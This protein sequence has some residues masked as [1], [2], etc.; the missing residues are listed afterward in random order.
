MKLYLAHLRN[1]KFF[2]NHMSN[3]F[4]NNKKQFYLIRGPLGC[5][6]SLF[7]RKA[8]NNFIG[9]SD[10]LG[11]NYFKQNYQFLFCNLLNPLNEI[12]PFN[13]ISC[14]FRKIYLLIKLE[15]RINEVI[16]VI[17]KL[18]LDE[19]TI[20]DISFI[21]SMGRDDIKLLE[22]YNKDNKQ[23]NKKRKTKNKL[24]ND[25]NNTPNSEI[26]KFEGP[27]IYENLEM[28]NLFFYEMI[29]LYFKYLKTK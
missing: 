13:I 24:I 21:L 17:N 29:K 26:K 19:K 25:I 16:N 27:F 23:N 3:I 11:E 18:A 1:L 4:L 14:I 28:I 7:I 22:E 2:T 12:L 6:K 8:L 5:G 10:I 9:N 15:K 20:N